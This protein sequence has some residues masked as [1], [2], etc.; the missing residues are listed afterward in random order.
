M[1]KISELLPY[2]IIRYIYEIFSVTLIQSVFRKNRSLVKRDSIIGSRVLV[3]FNDYFKYGTIDKIGSLGPDYGH[4]FKY[5]IRLI[6]AN[7]FPKRCYYYSRSPSLDGPRKIIFLNPWKNT[8][9]C[10][11]QVKGLFGNF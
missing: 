11:H 5:R 1:H 10:N 2:D 4:H 7:F 6:S 8:K 9:F 3:L